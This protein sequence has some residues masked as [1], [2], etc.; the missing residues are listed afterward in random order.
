MSEGCRKISSYSELSP[1]LKNKFT[2]AMFDCN[3]FT[4][5]KVH[6]KCLHGITGSLQGFPVVGKPWNIYRLQENPMI[7]MEFP[8]N[9]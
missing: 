6:C 7:I 8:G 3:A 1:G 2:I 5:H 4:R 9:L